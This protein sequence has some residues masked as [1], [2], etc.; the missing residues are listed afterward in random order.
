MSALI[1]LSI[2]AVLLYL[3]TSHQPKSCPRCGE[4]HERDDCHKVDDYPRQQV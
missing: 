3:L 4:D 2:L 1:V